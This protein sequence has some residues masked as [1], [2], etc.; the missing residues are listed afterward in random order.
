ECHK[1]MG[2]LRRSGLDE[3]VEDWT[4]MLPNGPLVV[5]AHR[6]Y[7]FQPPIYPQFWMH[8]FNVVSEELRDAIEALQPG[9][10]QFVPIQVF[11]TDEKDVRHLA[12]GERFL[13]RPPYT[14]LTL[15]P[16]LSDGLKLG[17]NAYPLQQRLWSLMSSK[18]PVVVIDPT[19]PDLHF[20]C[21]DGIGNNVFISD[22]MRDAMVRIS[23]EMKLEFEH[24]FARLVIERVRRRS[25]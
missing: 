11:Y 17:S 1:P 14:D 25:A 20:F 10:Q 22:E 16:E 13:T 7:H 12:P 21:T 5:D 18:K 2:R 9:R 23:E 8:P 3:P 24:P 4:K 15:I 19:D 6:S